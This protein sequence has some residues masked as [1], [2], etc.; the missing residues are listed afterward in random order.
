MGLACIRCRLVAM[1]VA[2]DCSKI[3]SMF[4]FTGQNHAEYDACRQLNMQHSDVK[5]HT[6]LVRLR[7]AS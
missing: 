1:G 3:A 2:R 7:L 4:I 6:C 5:S